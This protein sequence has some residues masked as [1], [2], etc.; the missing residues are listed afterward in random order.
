MSCNDKTSE[1]GWKIT[2]E[3][4]T[5]AMVEAGML[6]MSKENNCAEIYEAMLAATP[7]PPK[8][9]IPPEVMTALDRMCIPLDESYLK[10]ITAQ[11]DAKCMALIREY[12]LKDQ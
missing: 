8:E 12:I 5:T 4:S 7:Q 3:K 1:Q 11:E 10:G 6:A 9:A 2:P